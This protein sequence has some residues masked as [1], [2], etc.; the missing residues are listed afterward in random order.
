MAQGGIAQWLN[1]SMALLLN[2]VDV[3]LTPD[4]APVERGMLMSSRSLG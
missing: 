3:G 4:P 1:G 2:G